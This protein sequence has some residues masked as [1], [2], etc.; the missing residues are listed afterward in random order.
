MSTASRS[1]KRLTLIAPALIVVAVAIALLF[2]LR[3]GTMDAGAKDQGVSGAASLACGVTVSDLAAVQSEV[4]AAQP[5]STVCLR[6]GSYGKLALDADKSGADVTVR[7]ENPGKATI[8]GADLSGSH[9]A[10]AQFDV[11]GEIT[12]EPGSSK[13]SVLHNSVG[14]G[15]FGVEAGPTT[16][17][18]ISDT[19]IRGNSFV[20]P[21]GEDAIRLNRY[22]DSGD[23]DHYGVLIEGNEITNVRENGNHSDCLQSV[24]GGDNLYFRRNYVHDNRC[25]GFFVNDQPRA[26]TNVVIQDNLMLRNAEPCDPP[27]SRCGPPLIVQIFGPTK[28]IR[29]RDNTIWTPEDDSPVALREGPFG[30]ATV[31]GNVFYRGWSDWSRGFPRFSEGRNVVCRWEA[32]LPRLSSKSR[33]DCSPGF[34]DPAADDYRVHSGAGVDWSPAGQHYGP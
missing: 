31:T 26:I 23:P 8:A 24:W 32:T 3:G 18:S 34:L 2:A 27:G 30:K 25:Q 12:I 13:I 5:G 20:G 17:T 22:H 7:A 9:L 28:G 19:T 16:T 1:R 11:H 33:R 14:G 6:D 29:L 10:L 21:F 4:S 15:Y